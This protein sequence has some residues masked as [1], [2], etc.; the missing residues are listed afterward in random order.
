MFPVTFFCLTWNWILFMGS[1]LNC[2]VWGTFCQVEDPDDEDKKLWKFLTENCILENFEL[3]N[4][5]YISIIQK[6]AFLL[7][8]RWKSCYISA[9]SWPILI[10]RT[11]LEMIL[12][13]IWM[14]KLNK[15]DLRSKSC[16]KMALK[17]TEGGKF[18]NFVQ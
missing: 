12:N 1:F 2:V 8:L 17:L 7:E 16:P 6:F 3:N 11:D 4:F 14:F 9:E 13:S 18:F 5:T 10:P 15:R